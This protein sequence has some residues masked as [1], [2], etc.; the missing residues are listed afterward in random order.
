MRISQE[1]SH[2]GIKAKD[3]ISQIRRDK[4]SKQIQHIRFDAEAAV[5]IVF[6][7]DRVYRGNNH[8]YPKHEEDRIE[9][10]KEKS[11]PEQLVF[12]FKL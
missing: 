8:Q 7:G 10:V 9:K 6:K 5:R 2:E 11:V 3:N 1:T 4:E 12:V